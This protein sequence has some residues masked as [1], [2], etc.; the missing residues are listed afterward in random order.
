MHQSFLADA[1]HVLSGP[2]NCSLEALAS[3]TA[4]ELD[5]NGLARIRLPLLTEVRRHLYAR[6]EHATLE[7]PR[8]ARVG[9]G[10]R[11]LLPR[12]DLPSLESIGFNL[13]V[14]EPSLASLTLPSLVTVGGGV[15][16]HHSALTT[17]SLPRLRRIA[18]EL[19]I[20]DNPALTSLS[21]PSLS[22]IGHDPPAYAP[23]E[24]HEFDW[25]RVRDNPALASLDLSSLTEVRGD[26]TVGDRPRL[27]SVSASSAS[28]EK[29][30]RCWMR[31]KC[32]ASPSP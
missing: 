21:L 13:S 19:D 4:L 27:C 18:H 7:L 17:L 24:G 9:S 5:R 11:L 14:F 31:S 28:S 20:H 29:L 3:V 15:V 12:A 25:L 1:C 32:L 10:L 23:I 8:L 26:C 30:T 6:E 2:Q 22:T 16:I